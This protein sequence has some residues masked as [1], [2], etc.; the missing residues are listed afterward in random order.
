MLSLPGAHNDSFL[1]FK[2][3]KT[4]V[5]IVMAIKG[6]HDNR[7]ITEMVPH[8]QHSSRLDFHRFLSLELGS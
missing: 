8:F 7:H 5:V 2:G 6:K 3:S 1:L 4:L